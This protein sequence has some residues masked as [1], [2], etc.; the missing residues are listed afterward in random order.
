MPQEP[1]PALDN[2]AA[3]TTAAKPEPPALTSYMGRLE[4]SI[5]RT[6][7]L[8]EM[9]KHLENRSAAQ[10]IIRATVVLNHA[11]LEDLLRTLAE[12]ALPES[13]EA[14]LKEIPLAGSRGRLE[15]FHL[16]K[17]AQFRG[18]T[19]DSLIRR[20][21]SELLDRSNFNNV[22]E[23]ARLLELLGLDPADYREEFPI[24]GAMIS[25]RHQIVHKGDRQP[26]ESTPA[27]I[28]AFEALMW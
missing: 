26:S 19:V 16:G 8:L 18:D 7:A 9:A 15:R 17:L 3:N 22:D 4:D 11:Y 28:D 6:L 24:L 5:H 23:I 1:T 27:E 12:L 20:S 25:R 13:G 21:V 14:V 2:E 10:D